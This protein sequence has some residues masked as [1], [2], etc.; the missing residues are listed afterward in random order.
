MNKENYRELLTSVHCNL[1]NAQ[2][3][4]DE[5]KQLINDKGCQNFGPIDIENSVD[6]LIKDLI[7]SRLAF[8]ERYLNEIKS[9]ISD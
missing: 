5:L 3:L 1:Q 9:R 8:A 7:K 6:K 2:G 4:S